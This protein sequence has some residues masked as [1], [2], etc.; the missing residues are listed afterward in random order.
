MGVMGNRKQDH[1]VSSLLELPFCASQRLCACVGMC[2]SWEGVKKDVDND[3]VDWKRKKEINKHVNQVH[4]VIIFYISLYPI[5]MNAHNNHKG[6]LK[7]NDVSDYIY[8]LVRT[9]HNFCNHHLL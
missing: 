7:S 9:A 1:S 3:R 4:T 5:S 6:C 2:M 8:L